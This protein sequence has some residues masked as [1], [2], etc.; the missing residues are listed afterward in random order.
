[1]VCICLL[2]QLSVYDPVWLTTVLWSMKEGSS[3]FRLFCLYLYLSTEHAA[4]AM[5]SPRASCTYW[6]TKVTSTNGSYKVAILYLGINVKSSSFD[7]NTF[8]LWDNCKSS[9][10]KIIS[11]RSFVRISL[12]Q[13]A[14]FFE[15]F[16]HVTLKIQSDKYDHEQQGPK[17]LKIEKYFKFRP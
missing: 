15:A 3:P 17:R 5:E 1:M 7:S 8:S 9:T 10:S 13:W 16:F 6:T 2:R 14:W 11:C 4:P 12:W